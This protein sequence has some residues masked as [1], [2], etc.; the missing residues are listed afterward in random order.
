M[1]CAIALQLFCIIMACLIPLST[2][3]LHT[4]SLALSPYSTDDRM[5][6]TDGL[7]DE[8]SF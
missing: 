3:R 8:L 6:S 5:K 7:L 2:A 1:F 4:H